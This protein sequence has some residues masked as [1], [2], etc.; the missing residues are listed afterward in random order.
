M[1]SVRSIVLT[2]ANRFAKLMKGSTIAVVLDP[3]VASVFQ[4]S[5][6]VNSML[7]SVISALPKPLRARSKAR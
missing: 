1:T 5:E 7:R 6:A 2:M 3:D 4:T